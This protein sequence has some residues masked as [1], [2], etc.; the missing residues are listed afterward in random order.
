MRRKIEKREYRP[1]TAPAS[2]PPSASEKPI[3]SSPKAAQL[4]QHVDQQLDQH[5]LDTTPDAE[6]V[7]EMQALGEL[8]RQHVEY[9]YHSLPMDLARE[10]LF[11]ELR[12]LGFSVNRSELLSALASFKWEVRQSILQHVVSTVIFSG[13]GF[14]VQQHHSLLPASMSLFLSQI[15][16]ASR[17]AGGDQGKK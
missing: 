7:R 11:K 2:I 9:N 5:F 17:D 16:P 3:H 6:I 13:V 10:Q 4:D 14:Q 8:I 12:S 1:A 15:A